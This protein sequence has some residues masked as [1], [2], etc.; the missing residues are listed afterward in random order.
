[1]NKYQKH[2]ACSYSYKLVCVND[3]FSTPFKSCL[4]NNIV[5]NFINTIIG[6][7]KYCSEHIIVNLELVMN[8]EDHEDFQKSIKCWICDHVYFVVMLK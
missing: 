8:K 1:M 6:E 4:G 2:V 7:G 5:Y 3:N